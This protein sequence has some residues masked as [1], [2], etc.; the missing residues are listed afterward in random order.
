MS[1]LFQ[2]LATNITDSLKMQL[3]KMANSNFKSFCN[4][5][6]ESFGKD[7]KVLLLKE[8]NLPAAD[9]GKA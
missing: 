5:T 3:N 4:G 7:Q 6:S 2:A 8:K 9:I 1:L